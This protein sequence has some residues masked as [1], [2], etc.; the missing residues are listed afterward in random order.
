MFKV[1]YLKWFNRFVTTDN[2]VEVSDAMLLDL[3]KKANRFESEKQAQ[4]YCDKLNKLFYWN[5]IEK[6]KGVK[7][8]KNWTLAKPTPQKTITKYILQTKKAT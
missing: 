1:S 8:W 2:G 4:K 5:E 6:Q 3:L 7:I